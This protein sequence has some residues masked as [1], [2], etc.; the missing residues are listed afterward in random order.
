[1]DYENAYDLVS[2]EFLWYMLKR[3]GFCDKWIHWMKGCITSSTIPILVNGSPTFKFTPQHGLRQGDPLAPFLFNV[4]VEALS[5]L[6]GHARNKNAYKGWVGRNKVA[7]DL[8][9]YA[10]D[11]LFIGVACLSN[12]VAIKAMMRCFEM[13]SDLKV[14]FNKSFFVGIGVEF[15]VLERW[16]NVL[17]YRWM[18]IPFTYLGPPIMVIRGD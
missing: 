5:K 9:Q 3:L 10:D 11:M 2:W 13:A 14:N 12:M 15:E 7:V 4:V 18:T 1:M 16:A 8:L 6:M 17:N